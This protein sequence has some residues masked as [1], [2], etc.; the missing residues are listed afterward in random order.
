M[1]LL[2]VKKKRTAIER[3]FLDRSGALRADD[4]KGA[5]VYYWL[6]VLDNKT[7]SLLSHVSI[8]MAVL[9]IFFGETE[10]GTL[11]RTLVVVELF[12]YLLI[13]LG[14]LLVVFVITP[15]DNHASADE[16]LERSIAVLM[17]RRRMYN[18][19]MV[20]TW[21]VTFAFMLTLVAKFR[22]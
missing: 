9:S 1:S 19:C 20:A 6:D 22:G 17:W 16:E 3:R 12:C 15:N 21:V 5:A 10:A 13:S 2:E 18:V 4:G 11:V 8:M 7:S 14:C